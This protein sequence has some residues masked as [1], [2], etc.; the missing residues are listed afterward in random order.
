[1]L[2]QDTVYFA[3]SY[4]P[5]LSSLLRLAQI[6]AY[7][8]INIVMVLLDHLVILVWVRFCR[9]TL[10][11]PIFYSSKHLTPLLSPS[12]DRFI[13]ITHDSRQIYFSAPAYLDLYLRL[14]KRQRHTYT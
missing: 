6:V 7:Q 12:Y 10:G 2:F 14:G 4:L 1:M 3:T 9:L 11:K 8:K 13:D 5:V